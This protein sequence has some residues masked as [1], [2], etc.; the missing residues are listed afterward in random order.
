MKDFDRMHDLHAPASRVA[1]ALD[2][3]CAADVSR[4]AHARA[5]LGD[6]VQLALGELCRHLRVLEV[7]RTRGT[8]A[9]VALR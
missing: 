7:V 6:V 8:T 9:H 5:G 4:D 2:L 3:H 1:F